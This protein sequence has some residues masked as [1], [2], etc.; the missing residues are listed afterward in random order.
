MNIKASFRYN[1][2]TTPGN[3]CR[4]EKA[5]ELSPDDFFQL[6]I[7]PLQECC[8]LLTMIEYHN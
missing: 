3:D 1:L 6:Q 5:V 7:G 8:S 4:I 2:T